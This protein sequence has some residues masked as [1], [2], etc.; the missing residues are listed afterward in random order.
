MRVI[1]LK[2]L[3]KVGKRFDTADV[4]DGYALN[5][6]IPQGLAEHA[7]TGRAAQYAAQRDA[8]RA[9]AE[10]HAAARTNAIAEI[11]GSEITIA[12]S[13]NEKGVLY[14]KLDAKKIA[15][16]LE[17]ERGIALPASH[18]ALDDVIQETGSHTIQV[19]GDDTSAS[20]TLTVR[21]D[22]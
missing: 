13:A 17:H 4:S 20:F 1:L 8:E 2:D 16:A 7:G 10:E 3:P 12:R 6:L 5:Y 15:A 18:I 19:S 22:E 14:E 21:A 11:D 9:V